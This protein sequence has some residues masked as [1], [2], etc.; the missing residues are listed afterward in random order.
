VSPRVLVVV[1]IAGSLLAGVGPATVLAA[2]PA[3]SRDTRTDDEGGSAVLTHRL[4]EASRGYTKARAAAQTARN[5]QRALERQIAAAKLRA[6]VLDAEVQRIGA[7]AYRGS[8]LGTAGELARATSV[9]DA[10]D[11]ASLMDNLSRRRQRTIADLARTQRLLADR[12][13]DVAKELIKRR[14]AERTMAA[15]RA[16][17][18]R[19]LEEAGGG[20]PAPGFSA[21]SLPVKPVKPAAKRRPKAGPLPGPAAPARRASDGSWPS[22]R[23]NQDDPT[24]NACLTPRTL[25]ALRAVKAAGFT[26][27]VACFRQASFGEHPKGRACDFA[28]APGGFGGAATGADRQYGNRLAAWLI[29]NADRLAV[30][31]VIWYRQIWLP[32]T[33]W[34]AYSSGSDPSAAHTNHVHLSVQ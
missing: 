34:R 18:Q 30:L 21:Q 24:T 11:G 3:P 7:E 1:L 10:L 28:A 2:P 22:E 14:K 32:G 4:D 12:R 13:S 5:T 20:G 23:C 26:H 8:M 6:R 17:A 9:R 29:A 15:R 19:A 16:A 33:G 25:H 27:Y 31:Y